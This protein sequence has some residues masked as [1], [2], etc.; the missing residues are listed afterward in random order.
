MAK[1]FQIK[2]GAKSTMPTLAQGEL[3]FVTD[4]DAEELHI[5]NGSENIQIARQDYVDSVA[6]DK[7][8]VTGDTMTGPL[9]IKTDTAKIWLE[10]DGGNSQLI[11]NATASADYGTQIIDDSGEDNETRLIVLG[12]NSLAKSVYF[13]K[14]GEDYY[15]LGTHNPHTHETVDVPNTRDTNETPS[16]YFT[17][18]AKTIVTEFKNASVIGLSGQTYCKLTTYTAWNDSTGC[19]PV[20]EAIIGNTLYIRVGIS[21]DE[22]GEWSSCVKTSDISYVSTT[23]IDAM[24]AGT[25]TS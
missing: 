8:D 19:Y 12:A 22:W 6:S 21:D 10:T 25:Y 23:D 20:Q 3:G 17:N 18:Y 13:T 15:L 7:V 14:G 9:K 24:L 16:W 1:T 11:K 5:G 4:S 2:R